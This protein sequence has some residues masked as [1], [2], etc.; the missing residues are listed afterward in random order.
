M[1]TLKVDTIEDLSAGTSVDATYV[2]H[3]T[4]KVWVNLKGTDTF[5]VTGSVN[6]TSAT[7]NSAGDYTLTIAS[8]MAD[9]T[10][11][12]TTG[13]THDSAN[14]LHDFCPAPQRLTGSYDHETAT[15]AGT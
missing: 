4:A 13:I 11:T 12:I 14:D 7:D 5:G 15:G 2:V 6:L 9:V 8:D 3:G 10:Y 1:S